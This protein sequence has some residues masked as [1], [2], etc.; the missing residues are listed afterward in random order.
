MRATGRT[1]VYFTSKT[2]REKDRPT[3]DVISGLSGWNSKYGAKTGA[4][5]IICWSFHGGYCLY[6]GH[7]LNITGIYICPTLVLVLDG[8]KA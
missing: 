5:H 4:H 1:R 2:K 3:V 6:Y 7:F 8:E